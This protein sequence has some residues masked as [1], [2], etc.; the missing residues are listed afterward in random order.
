LLALSGESRTILK[1]KVND[2]TDSRPGVEIGELSGGH[3]VAAGFQGFPFSRLARKDLSSREFRKCPLA[4]A[5]KPVELEDTGSVKFMA[6]MIRI[7]H[8]PQEN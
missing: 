4:L 7:N 6:P 3:S 5:H 8:A 2:A 1:R